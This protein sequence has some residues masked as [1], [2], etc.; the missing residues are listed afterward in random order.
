[1]RLTKLHVRG[2]RS[3]KGDAT[4]ATDDR[5]TILIGAN[6]HGKSNLLEAIQC[7]N[8]DHPIEEDDRNWDL[9]KLDPV[10]IKWHFA[11]TETMIDGLKKFSPPP[12]EPDTAAAAETTTAGEKAEQASGEPA[13]TV[14]SPVIKPAALPPTLPIGAGKEIVF[15]RDFAT[16]KVKVTSV[17]VPI[18][19]EFEENILALRPRVELFESPTGNVVDQVNLSQLETPAFEFMQGIFRLA[20]LWETRKTIFVQ[21]D[22]TSRKLDEASGALT[23]ILNDQ[24]NQGKELKWKFEH[25]GTNGD[26]IVIKIQDPA[27]KG[28]FTRPSLRSSGFRTYFLLS[29]IVY[30]RSQNTPGN[31]HIYLFDEPGTYLHPSAQLDLQRSFETIADQAQLVYTTHSLFLISKNYPSRNRVVSKRNS[32][33]RI[34]QKP[35]SKNWKSVRQSLGILLSNNFLIADKTLLV[36]GPSDTVYLLDALKRLKAEEKIDVDLN[37][38]SIVDA[39]DGQNFAAMAKIMLS[40]GRSVVALVDGDKGGKALVTQLEKTCAAEISDRTLRIHTLPENR[41]SEDIFAHK[42][43]LRAAVKAACA[44]LVEDGS[45]ILKEGAD[46]DGAV[47]EVAPSSSTTLGRVI[48]KVTAAL[49]VPA[50]RMSKLLIAIKYE[51][52]AEAAKASP[53]AEALGELE[54]IRDLLD[55]RSEKSKQTGVFEEVDT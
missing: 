46:V 30:A 43:S 6:D 18:L 27:I 11:V 36:E 26:T 50:V 41:S 20:G 13:T 19:Q 53:P 39:G 15:T 52:I 12:Q 17:P 49:F 33:T 29:M 31:S 54:K 22:T 23:K 55:L 38:M 40:E 9:E 34:D 16:N 32:G 21:N 5:V 45:R 51:D 2:Y 48:D 37:D 35:F 25:T 1:M 47:E 24:W 28:R 8:D 4:L 42:E 7:L 44:L 3:I 14:T 10:H